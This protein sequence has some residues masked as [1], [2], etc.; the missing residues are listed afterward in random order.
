VKTGTGDFE[1]AETVLFAGAAAVDEDAT[2]REV[3]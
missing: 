2:A 3:D 1:A